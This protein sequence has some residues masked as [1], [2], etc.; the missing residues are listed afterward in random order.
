MF[1][2]MHIAGRGFDS[3]LA[4][5]T[6]PFQEERRCF[7]V[8]SHL[9]FSG[10][11]LGLVL[12]KPARAMFFRAFSIYKSALAFVN[13]DWKVSKLSRKVSK[14]AWRVANL[15]R[16]DSKLAWRVS[17]LSRRVSKLSRNV[18][19]LAWRVANLSR[20]D[21]KLAWKVVNL[22]CQKVFSH[23]NAVCTP[24]VKGKHFSFLSDAIINQYIIKIFH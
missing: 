11:Y 24:F 19:K 21:S 20:K 7:F 14:L 5:I 23:K 22:N 12:L 2:L 13:L 18:S 4:V 17:K 8:F 16:N 6:F 1:R 3:D 15:S 9:K 10:F